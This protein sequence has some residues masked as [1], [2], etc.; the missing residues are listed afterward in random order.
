[1]DV[2]LYVEARSPIHRLDPRAK[3]AA[4]VALIFLAVAG[5]QPALPAALVVL[6]LAA[7]QIGRAWP[8]LRRVRA[9][10]FIIGSFSTVTWAVFARGSTPLWGPVEAE[11]LLFAVG[12][13]L[14]L[15]A[16]I[17]GSVVF[18]ATTK[19]EEITAGLIRLG[20]PYPVAFAF[21]T[22]L[23]LVPTFV[24]SGLTII[25][26]QKSRGLD[27]ESGGLLRRMRRHLPLM[28][29]ILAVAIRSTNQLAMALE[30]RGFRARPVRTQYLQL[31]FGPA[32]WALAILSLV[33]I[34]AALYLRLFSPAL[35]IPGLLT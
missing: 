3:M 31:R 20:L 19:N 25:E 21:S 24:G 27:V 30:S 35:R 17:A 26:A 22:A 9:L 28:V 13:G 14:K 34:G 8:A 7:A 15:I 11:A 10:L 4:L 12:T 29:P 1:M 2:Y 5:D 18:L 16:T 32:D 6:V 33:L 23:R